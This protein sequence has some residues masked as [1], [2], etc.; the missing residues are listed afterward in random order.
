MKINKTHFLLILIV[1]SLFAC[2]TSK[3]NAQKNPGRSGKNKLTEIEQQECLSIFLEANKEK[4][5]DNYSKAG[6]LFAECIRKNPKDDASFYELASILNNDKKF[7]DALILAKE[8]VSLNPQNDWYQI[9]LAEIY[10]EK[11]RPDDATKIYEKL[12]KKHPDKLDYY[13]ELAMNYLYSHKYN[14][15]LNVYNTLENI[16]GISEELSV[17]KQ[18]IYQY[19][20]K[21]D[22][23]A[24]EIIK[25]INAFPKVTR[26]KMLLADVYLSS[27][28]KEKA[29]KIYE[30]VLKADPQNG[31]V[32]LSLADYY[33]SIGDNEKFYEQIKLAFSNPNVEINAKVKILLSYFSMT[34]ASGNEKF[35]T[36]AYDLLDILIKTHP[37]EAIAYS[38]YAD[39]LTRDKKDELARDMFLKVIALDKSKYPVWEQLLIIESDLHHYQAL[40]SLSKA[41]IEL[42]PEQPLLY[43]LSGFANYHFKKYDEAAKVLK[44]GLGYA[45]FNEK[46]KAEFYMY[47]GDAYYQLKNY[48]ESDAAYE[49][50]LKIDSN[51]ITL[52][53]NYSYYLTLRGE[54]LEKA[55]ILSKKSNDLSPD[56]S[57]YQDTYAWV[58]FCMKD[59]ENA[60]VW[61]KKALSHNGTSNSVIVEHYGDILYKLN[62]KDDAFEQWKKAKE[63]GKGSE[64]LDKKIETKM[65][66]P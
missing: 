8:A 42:F 19:T 14:E 58:L 53:N 52:L 64:D 7:D 56:V 66:I 12:V 65:L 36:E 39:F 47:L 16:I 33:R 41:A 46:L 1:L 25:L 6:S 55:K 26:Y 37:N 10:N 15:A 61:I 17:Q 2:R 49:S 35:L 57:S 34:D 28:Q 59:Y 4:I 40:D 60:L 31:L 20:N 45:A 13:Y 22:K 24:E 63:I 62:K 21:T 9:L 54:K 30:E 23:A 38:I 11:K 48:P 44:E 3:D 43:L 50:S 18:T 32:N 5:L 29:Y 51:N 27:K